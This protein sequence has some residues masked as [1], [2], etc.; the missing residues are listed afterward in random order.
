MQWESKANWK[1]RNW[2]YTNAASTDVAKTIARV[3]K[4]MKELADQQGRKE[5][6]VQIR[7][8]R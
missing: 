1:D 3:K 5:K 4:E 8:A 2:K 6:I 7:K